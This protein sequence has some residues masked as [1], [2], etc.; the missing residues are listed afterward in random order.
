MVRFVLSGICIIFVLISCAFADD[1]AIQ[2]I[3]VRAAEKAMSELSLRKA[4]RTYL[5]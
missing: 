4:M 2:E 1:A 3:G 5:S